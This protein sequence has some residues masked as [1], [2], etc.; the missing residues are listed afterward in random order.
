MKNGPPKPERRTKKTLPRC[1]LVAELEEPYFAVAHVTAPWGIRGEMKIEIL[2][3]NPKR[4]QPGALLYFHGTPYR[5]EHCKVMPKS[6]SLKLKG[7]D[8][9]NEAEAMRDAYLD[10]PS[11]ELGGLEPDVFYL[12]QIIGL[13]VETTDGRPVGVVTAVMQTGANDVYVATLDGHETLIPAIG[14]VVKQIDVEGG[15]MVIEAIPG[16]LD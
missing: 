9:R 14:Q 15:K 3:D 7:I 6:V 1:S 12:H 4:F 10:V 13:N 11:S 2:S 16:L 8:T 5:I